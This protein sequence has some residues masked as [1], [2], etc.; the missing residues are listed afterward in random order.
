[1][2]DVGTRKSIDEPPNAPMFTGVKH[3]KTSQAS[4]LT[5]A[6]TEMA[7]STAVAFSQSNRPSSS[8]PDDLSKRPSPSS[9]SPGKLVELRGKYIQQLRELHSLFEGG[10]RSELEFVSEKDSILH[11]LKMMSPPRQ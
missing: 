10:A 4:A 6:F 11:Q 8:S 7:S 9:S 2:L 5:N 3:G 1:M